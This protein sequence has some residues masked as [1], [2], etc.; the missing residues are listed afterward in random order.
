[1]DRS[2]SGLGPV[3]IRLATDDDAID[4]ARLDTF[5]FPGLQTFD[6]TVTQVLELLFLQRSHVAV[7]NSNG[8][9]QIVG[10]IVV[11]TGTAVPAMTVTAVEIASFAVDPSYRNRGIGKMLFD[12][13][14]AECV[15]YEVDFVRLHVNVENR[16]VRLYHS[17]GFRFV[18]TI[19]EYYETED[20][21]LARPQ[22]WLE[23][24]SKDAYVMVKTFGKGAH[25]KGI[26]KRIADVEN[27]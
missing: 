17:L 10:Y 9:P 19:N 3:T 27:L 7:Q 15:S 18:K 8:G 23:G 22:L 1:M 5:I 21:A 25:L 12:V 24:L 11:N 13:V 6:D 2:L 20:A 26:I 4:I 16:A 14:L